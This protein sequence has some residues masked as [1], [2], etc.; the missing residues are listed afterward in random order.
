MRR[1]PRAGTIYRERGR[2]VLQ[3]TIDGPDGPQRTRHGSY[4]DTPDGWADADKDRRILVGVEAAGD[5]QAPSTLT[6]GAYLESWLDGLAYEVATRNIRPGTLHQYG[7]DLRSKIIPR[8]GHVALTDLT[9]KMLRRLYADLLESG[10]RGERPLAP[11]S[12]RNYG[13]TLRR[14]LQDAV[15]DDLLK[16]NPADAVKLPKVRR[17]K[18]ETWT[19]EQTRHALN[20]L[21]EPLRSMVHLTATTGMRRS[22]VLGLKWGA[23]D[24]D[25]GAVEVTS[26][27][28][29]VANSPTFTPL[30]KTDSSRRRIAL[31]PET[32][33]MLR[34]HRVRQV[35]QRLEAGELWSDEYGLVFTDE[36]GRPYSPDRYTRTFQSEAR[37]LGLPPIGVHGLRHSLATTALADGVP[38]KVVAERLGHSSVA[39]TLDRYSHVSEEQ[40]REAAVSLASKIIGR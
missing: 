20:N 38:A 28:L 29:M 3:L 26:T 13:T 25:A 30:T 11:K 17:S 33:K 18:V 34:Q 21:E 14:A 39:T 9:A 10:G 7:V 22:E 32:V 19:P 1:K 37:R 15:E 31:D 40:D 8:V 36:I 12:V 6:V 27:L 2:V 23:T 16:S 5:L 4:P 24:L 35:E